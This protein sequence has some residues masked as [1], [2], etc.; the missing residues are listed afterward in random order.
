AP[1]ASSPDTTSLTIPSNVALRKYY[2][3]A[4]ADDAGLVAESDETNNCGASSGVV[5][6]TR[7]DLVETALSSPP[8]A[9]SPGSSFKITDTVLNQGLVDAGASKTRYYL[10]VDGRRG[11]G[12]ILLTGSRSVSGVEAGLSFEGSAL[13]VTIPATAPLGT[14]YL[15]ACADDTSLVV[16]TDEPN[17]VLATTPTL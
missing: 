14:Y 5:H 9:A 6:V 12:N 4:C 7:P 17:N 8:A 16:Q 13:T 3:L 2:V 15:L 11:G 1:G 10:S